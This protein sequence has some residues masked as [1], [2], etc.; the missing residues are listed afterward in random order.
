MR[1]LRY[2]M[3]D[4]AA[5]VLQ[6]G[7]RRRRNHRMEPLANTVTE[8][9]GELV[10]MVVARRPVVVLQYCQG[11]ARVA[12]RYLHIRSPLRSQTSP[13]TCGARVCNT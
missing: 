11:E 1:R 8:W 5:V 9:V 6:D 13:V 7:V 2:G 12:K 4:C 3:D 10:V